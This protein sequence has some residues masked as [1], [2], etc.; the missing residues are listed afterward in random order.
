MISSTPLPVTIRRSQPASVRAASAKRVA[1]GERALDHARAGR[2]VGGAGDRGEA[3]AAARRSRRCGTTTC[4]PAASRRRGRRPCQL[5]ACAVIRI[6]RARRSRLQRGE[7]RRGAGL[8][9]DR[10]QH[11]AALRVERGLEGVAGA[12]AEQRGAGHRR[13]LARAA[14]DHDDRSR[15]RG[16]TRPPR[17]PP[18][19]RGSA[20]RA[21]ARPGSSP[22]WPTAGRRAARACRSWPSTVPSRWPFRQGHFD[23]DEPSHFGAVRPARPRAPEPLRA[24]LED[25]ICAAITGGGAPPAPGCPP[26][27]SRRDPARL[28]RRRQRGLRADRRR[29]L[30]RDPPRR[31]PV[32]RAVPAAGVGPDGGPQPLAPR[33][34]R[35]SRAASA[36][37]LR[38]DL[39]AT[40][41]DLSAFPRRAWSAALR[42]VLAEMPDAALD[43][44]DPRGRRELRAELA[45]YLVRVRGVV[46]DARGP[47]RH[48]R[49]H[50]GAV[51]DLPGAARRAGR[52]R[53]AVEDPSLDDAWATIRSAGLEVVGLPVDEHGIRVDA[54]RR[55]RGAR[56]AR[57]PVPD[58]RGARARAAARAAGVG[59]DRDR[60]RLRLRVPLRP[61]AGRDA[62]AAR[63]RPRRLPRHGVED[64]R[65]GAA[66]R[67]AARAAGRWPRR[68]RAS[69]GRWTP[70][71]RRS[72]PAPTPACSPPARSTA[73]CAAP[74]A[75]TASAATRWSRRSRRGSRTAGSRA[76]PPGCTCCCGSRPERTRRRW[77]RALAERRIRIRGL[78][79]YRLTPRAG[80][81]GARDR[82]RPAPARRDR[83]GRRGSCATRSMMSPRRMAG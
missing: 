81:A 35:A 71:A 57:A 33:A 65:A 75:S 46:G 10:D 59:R 8:V 69:A 31:A 68:S 34:S 30:D 39:T 70:A 4:P 7:R 82:L 17:A 56:H 49:L 43:Y 76:S 44:G 79:G 72:T 52:R 21:P 26:R 53:V 42:R 36:P 22:P 9:R 77:S 51:A 5:R 40:A 83:R 58:R 38:L 14:A 25:A 74:G 24:Q 19:R 3:P 18:A 28:P 12:G 1:Q 6:V 2:R 67:L 47:G 11:A 55:R 54:L 63:A 32:V 80:R 41:P 23:A 20:P 73:T 16:S 37:P 13:V 64:A 48:E 50:A 45:A 62:A 66:A 15:P 61:R 29:G 60:G 78:A 27:A